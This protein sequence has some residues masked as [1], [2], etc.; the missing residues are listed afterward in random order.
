[1]N[2]T[3][4]YHDKDIGADGGGPIKSTV[5]AVTVFYKMNPWVQFG[6][7]ESAYSSYAV[8][9][10]SGGDIGVCNATKVGNQPVCNATDWRTEFGPVFTF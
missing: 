7:E 10:I 6:F 1:V 3:D 8:P 4:F 5:K 9:A 2:A